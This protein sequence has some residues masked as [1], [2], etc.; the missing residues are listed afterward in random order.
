MP[1]E[2]TLT[3]SKRA[4][5]LSRRSKP[6]QCAESFEKAQKTHFTIQAVKWWSRAWQEPNE[7]VLMGHA[8]WRFDIPGAW[9]TRP[10]QSLV[11]GENLRLVILRAALTADWVAWK[12]GRTRERTL[13]LFPSKDCRDRIERRDAEPSLKG[14]GNSIPTYRFAL[15]RGQDKGFTKLVE[16]C[17]A[18]LTAE[19][20]ITLEEF[21]ATPFSG[22][23]AVPDFLSWLL[24]A[25]DIKQHTI[26]MI[27]NELPPTSACGGTFLNDLPAHAF[28]YHGKGKAREK[29]ASRIDDWIMSPDAAGRVLCICAPE[30]SVGLTAFIKELWRQHVPTERRAWCYLPVSRGHATTSDTSYRATVARLYAFYSGLD[31]RLGDP[32]AGT[33]TT[34]E[35][36]AYCRLRMVDIP[37]VLIFDGYQEPDFSNDETPIPNLLSLVRDEPVALL[38]EHLL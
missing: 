15:I 31:T 4:T 26:S 5:P 25:A 29:F 6:T 35:R 23:E 37:T 2:A 10:T 9:V 30:M 8:Q 24:G 32:E 20:K 21:I 7:A 11:L 13:R 1:K 18:E 3:N 36:L 16:E 33:L 38:L 28:V 22:P 34:E 12:F 17:L 19:R 27:S 14:L